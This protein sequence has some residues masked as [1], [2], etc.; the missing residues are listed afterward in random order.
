MGH[1]PENTVASFEKAIALGCDEIETDVWLAG[2]GRLLISHDRPTDAALTLDAVLDLCRGRVGV[3][4]ELK[5]ERDDAR[6]GETGR[7]VATRLA[8]RAD[9]DAYVSSF[10]W[11]ALEGARAAAP[12]VRRAFVFS[13]SPD[14]AALVASARALGLWALHPNRAYVTRELVDAAHAAGLRVNA[15]TV[16][17]ADEIAAFGALGVDGIMSNWPE[18]IPKG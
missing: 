12:A 7:R 6:A 9:P 4:V 8:E 14:R 15:W 5:A 18:R 10:W 3:N 2:D 16:N 11:S 17:D 13:D 1:A